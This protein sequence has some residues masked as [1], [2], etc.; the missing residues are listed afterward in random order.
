MKSVEKYS[1][2]YVPTIQQCNVNIFPYLHQIFLIK[3][4]IRHIK[5]IE[6]LVVTSQSN[7]CPSPQVTT[8]L[9]LVCVCPG[10]I[11]IM[12]VHMNIRIEIY[13]IKLLCQGVSLPALTSLV[14]FG[15]ET[16]SNWGVSCP[17]QSFSGQFWRK[18]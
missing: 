13:T 8:M 5:Q 14:T 2:F 12:L 16:D 10:Q 9:K 3:K 15:E 11:S 18:K 17:S 6:S 7:S 4:E 1:N